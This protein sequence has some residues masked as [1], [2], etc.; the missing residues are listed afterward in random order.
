M[1]HKVEAGAANYFVNR[2]AEGELANA[3]VKEMLLHNQQ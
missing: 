1:T 2:Q 3:K